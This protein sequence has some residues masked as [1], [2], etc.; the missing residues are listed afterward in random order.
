MKSLRRIAGS[1]DPCFHR[2]LGFRNVPWKDGWPRQT[3]A[4]RPEGETDPEDDDAPAED[5]IQHPGDGTTFKPKWLW[6]LS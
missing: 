1:S 6:R 4:R 2:L 3:T 5:P